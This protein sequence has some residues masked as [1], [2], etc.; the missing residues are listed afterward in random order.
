MKICFVAD[1]IGVIGG[2]QKIL[3]VIANSL[4][5]NEKNEISILFNQNEKLSKTIKYPLNSN[6]KIFWSKETAHGKYDYMLSR[7]YT[8]LYQRGFGLKNQNFNL[9][10][11][12][13]IKERKAYINFFKENN[14][15]VIVGVAPYSSALLGMISDKISSKTVGWLHNSYER[16]FEYKD[17][18]FNLKTIYKEA[19][20]KLDSRIVLTQSAKK[21]F[22]KEFNMHFTHMY[23]PLTFQTNKYS[24]L[25]TQKILFVGRIFYPTKGLDLLIEIINK[26]TKIN[27]NF[28][29]VV[30]GDGPDMQKFKTEIE[31]NNLQSS[32]TVV[33]ESN[34]VIKDYLD[35]SIF[36]STSRVEGFGLVL[37]EAMECGLPVVSFSTEGPSEIILNNESGFLIDNYNTTDF[38][39]KLDALLRNEK[40]R[41]KM[42]DKS[43]NRASDF[44]LEVITEKWE[45]LFDKL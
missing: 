9:N 21:R 25:N 8:K 30:V 41:R 11:I 35:S 3:T 26:L 39:K 40:L 22:E 18:L 14:F 42:G 17:N 32:I 19:F 44:S 36:V 33:G 38:A 34:N 10:Q 6:V 28:E 2:Q 7:L 45:S 1:T 29:V 24:S 20:E 5:K 16:Y 37:T 4:A 12:F 13:P 31:N 15:D 27:D 23:N 43:K